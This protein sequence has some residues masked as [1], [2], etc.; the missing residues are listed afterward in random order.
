MVQIPI[1]SG[2]TD[3]Q[4]IHGA[5]ERDQ[6]IIFKLVLV[7]FTMFTGSDNTCSFIYICFFL[8][9]ICSLNAHHKSEMSVSQKYHSNDKFYFLQPDYQM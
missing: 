4:S 1:T 8:L 6:W 2:A 9:H 7:H 5:G 3:V